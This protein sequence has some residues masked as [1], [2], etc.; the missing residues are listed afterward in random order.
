LRK[1][2]EF[3]YFLVVGSFNKNRKF[4]NQQIIFHSKENFISGLKEKNDFP[5]ILHDIKKF[6]VAFDVKIKIRKP[7]L[8]LP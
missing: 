8:A 5:R 7:V 4:N 2:D 6:P 1:S 3:V